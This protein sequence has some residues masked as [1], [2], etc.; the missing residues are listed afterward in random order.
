MYRIN[1]VFVNLKTLME[2]C[3]FR[4]GIRGTPSNECSLRG[5]E[6][7]TFLIYADVLLHIPMTHR[8]PKG[9]N[10]TQS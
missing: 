4:H 2:S 9:T 10:G 7:A 6:Q 3:G 5:R 8:M 1:F